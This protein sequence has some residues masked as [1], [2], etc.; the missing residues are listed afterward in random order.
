MPAIRSASFAGD[1]ML[2]GCLRT[3]SW[4]SMGSTF[5]E[6][7]ELVCL[8]RKHGVQLREAAQVYVMCVLARRIVAPLSRRGYGAEYQEWRGRGTG[9]MVLPEGIELSTSPLPRECS[10]TELRQRRVWMECCCGEL[11]QTA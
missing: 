1:G 4:R 10:T 5:S 6:Q 2:G 8:H 3:R 7:H 9:G 11:E